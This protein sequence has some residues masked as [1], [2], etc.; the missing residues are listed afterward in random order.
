MVMSRASLNTAKNVLN[1]LFITAQHHIIV[2]KIYKFFP[3]NF[4]SGS[5]SVFHLNPVIF[6][7][8][9]THHVFR[10]LRCFLFFVTDIRE[11][12]HA[13]FTFIS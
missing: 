4:K 3:M 10:S 8:L 5:K 2:I 6:L 13:E 9:Q 7:F 11:L 12:K 1:L